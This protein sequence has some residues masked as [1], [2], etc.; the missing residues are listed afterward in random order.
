MFVLDLKDMRITRI[1][2]INI[3]KVDMLSA[4]AGQLY[5]RIYTRSLYPYTYSQWLSRRIF[6]A[7]AR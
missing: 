6:R 2:L 1:L 7:R 4:F 3:E 5:A